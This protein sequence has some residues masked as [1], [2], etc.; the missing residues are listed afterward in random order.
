MRHYRNSLSGTDLRTNDYMGWPWVLVDDDG[1][2]LP[3][4]PDDQALWLWQMLH[5][6]TDAYVLKRG[7]LHS[8]YYQTLSQSR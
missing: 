8:W 1:G 7:F 6:T 3:A 4:D 5:Q 2:R